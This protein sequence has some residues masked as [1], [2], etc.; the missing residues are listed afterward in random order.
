VWGGAGVRRPR[1]RDGA[2]GGAADRELRAGRAR[3]AAGRGHGAGDRA[4]GESRQGRREGAFGWVDGSDAR[5]EPVGA[6][7]ALGRGD[8]RRLRDF[9]AARERGA[10][11]SLSERG[12][13]GVV[14]EVLPSAL[15]RFE[16]DGEQRITA[17]IGGGI[18]RNF[19]RVLVGDRVSVALTGTDLTRGRILRRVSSK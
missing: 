9:D 16:I 2:A 19:V 17:H 5:R 10:R 6:L 14:V 7:R 12:V 4:D 18:E 1:H 11:Q 15:Y 8:A 3:A 13:E